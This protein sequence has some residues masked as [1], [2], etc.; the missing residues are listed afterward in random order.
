MGLAIFTT[1]RAGFHVSASTGSGI[2][3][4]RQ[5][6]GSW[7]APSGIH[8]HSVG[9]GFSAGADIYDCVCVINTREA[10]ETFMRTRLS[11]GPEVSVSAGPFGAGG[12]ADF[13]APGRH[14][15]EASGAGAGTTEDPSKLSAEKRP[16]HHRRRSSFSA[17]DP[18]F[19]YVKGRGLFAGVQVDGTVITERKE[20]NAAF[21]GRH[22]S[23]EQILSGAA[24]P[25]G[26]S[27][28]MWPQAAR[29][30]HEALHRAEDRPSDNEVLVPP[31]EATPG[32]QGPKPGHGMGDG[33]GQGG[34]DPVPRSDAPAH[35]TVGGGSAHKVTDELPAYSGSEGTMRGQ[36]VPEAGRTMP[37]EVPK[38]GQAKE[39]TV[40][41]EQAHAATDELPAY[42]GS[43][44][45]VPDEKN[46]RGV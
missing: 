12:G 4:A 17:F 33:Q 29:G 44:A 40:A 22:V 42:P 15:E 35:G 3:I 26:G 32:I 16:E 14:K 39:G 1:L 5:Q 38:A 11:L 31:T 37:D 28:N 18:V 13:G 45:P 6:D 8:V 10:L 36:A 41:G 20:A 24:L 19:T 7:G 21:Y 27:P 25:A 43:K 2:L 23:V 46:P 34:D 9:A 30:L